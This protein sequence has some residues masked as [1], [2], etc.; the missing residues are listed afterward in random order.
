MLPQYNSVDL[1][2]FNKHVFITSYTFVVTWATVIQQCSGHLNHIIILYTYYFYCF[3]EGFC[4]GGASNI[5]FKQ[6]WKLFGAKP[7]CCTSPPINNQENTSVFIVRC[8]YYYYYIADTILFCFSIACDSIMTV[9]DRSAAVGRAC[10]LLIINAVEFIFHHHE[11]GDKN[12][13]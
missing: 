3:S 5:V 4:G 1:S 2:F 12:T 11:S 13:V 8:Y 9:H 10:V 6:K 7:L